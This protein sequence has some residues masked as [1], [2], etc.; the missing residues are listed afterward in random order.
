MNRQEWQDLMAS[1]RSMFPTRHPAGDGRL[2]VHGRGPA[3]GFGHGETGLIWLSRS[4]DRRLTLAAGMSAVELEVRNAAESWSVPE[5]EVAPAHR[6]MR[7]KQISRH[8]SHPA[9]TRAML[10]R[11]LF[12]NGVS[13]ERSLPQL[14]LCAAQNPDWRSD[15][16]VGGSVRYPGRP[17][18]NASS[19]P[20]TV[21]YSGKGLGY[22]FYPKAGHVVDTHPRG[23]R[24]TACSKAGL[25][26]DPRKEPTAGGRM[27]RDIYLIRRQDAGRVARTPRTRTTV[28]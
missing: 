8:Q 14:E 12:E 1:C 18:G 19:A 5:V 23:Y 7:W 22:Y 2:V 20:G 27:S 17:D 3:L 13:G 9:T 28:S 6:A 25:G 24:V 15:R 26:D 10:F 21:A 4:L 11:E 16:N